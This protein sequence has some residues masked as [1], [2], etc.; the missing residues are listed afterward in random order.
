VVLGHPAPAVD[1]LVER[2]RPA[3][4][5][6]GDDEAG[7]SALW[8]DFDAGDDALGSAPAGGS[9]EELLEAPHSYSCAQ[10]ISQSNECQRALAEH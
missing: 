2:L 8:A 7:V 9:V 10:S 6:V 4:F 5:E 3:A 1:F